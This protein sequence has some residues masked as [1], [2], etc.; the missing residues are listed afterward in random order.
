MG[1]ACLPQTMEALL[2][3]GLSIAL[4]KMDVYLAIGMGYMVAGI[5]PAVL[6]PSVS[7]LIS[8]GYISGIYIYIYIM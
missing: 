7:L 2:V 1:L 8:Q 3:G 6:I 4:L 5:S